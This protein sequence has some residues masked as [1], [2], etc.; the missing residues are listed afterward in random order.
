MEDEEIKKKIGSI[1]LL[2]FLRDHYSPCNKVEDIKGTEYIMLNRDSC[3]AVLK[4]LLGSNVTNNEFHSNGFD[5]EIIEGL[6]EN[7]YYPAYSLLNWECVVKNNF[8]SLSVLI[9]EFGEATLIKQYSL[10]FRYRVL[11]GEKSVG[12]SSV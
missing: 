2:D 4:A 8:E 9:D 1:K 5:K 6:E 3:L 12:T 7:G 10:R 11:K